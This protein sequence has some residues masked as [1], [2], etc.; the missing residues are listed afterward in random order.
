MFILLWPMP[1]FLLSNTQTMHIKSFY[2]QQHCYVSLKTLYPGGIRTRV[3][4]L[5]RRVRCPLRH[6]ARA[7]GTCLTPAE[8]LSTKIPRQGCKKY[9]AFLSNKYFFYF[10]KHTNLLPAAKANL[11]TYMYTILVGLDPG[12]DFYE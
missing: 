8:L 7:T 1:L 2:A 11:H 5:L 3:F 10:V 9:A 12:V 4:L 6:A